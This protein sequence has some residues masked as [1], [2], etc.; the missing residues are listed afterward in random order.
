MK[1]NK[2][3][4]IFVNYFLGPLLF[5]WLSWSIYSQIKSQPGLQ[6]SWRYIREAFSGRALFYLLATILL[7]FVNLGIEAY[8]WQLAIKGVQKISF[9][10]AFK[11]V[12]SGVS[13]SITT[14]NRVGEYFGRILYVKEGNRIKVASL[15]IVSSMSQLMTT[16]LMGWIAL[17][18]MRKTITDA[19]LL[20]PIWIKTFFWGTFAALI[21]FVLFYFRLAWLVKVINKLPSFKRFSW[22][23][24]ALEQYNATLLLRFLSLSIS[25]FFIFILQ[26]YLLLRF[27]GVDVGF[28]QAWMSISVMFL[29]VAIIPT[30]ALFTDL[31]LKNEISLKLLGIFSAN[32]LGVSLTT[33]SIWLIN[34]VIPAVTGSLLILGIR[35]ILKNKNEV[36]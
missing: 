26:Y 5:L 24:E 27:F 33:L 35:K 23:I 29:L 12:L 2:N 9:M 31:T 34:L 25:R 22:A 19:Q 14:P 3:I 15:T 13:I 16:I 30:I 6:E 32:H 21:I 1:I 4:K 17:F 7:M 20:S 28:V 18:F 11:A 8:K 36:V 10:R